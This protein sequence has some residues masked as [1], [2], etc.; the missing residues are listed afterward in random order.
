VNDFAVRVNEL[1]SVE[2]LVKRHR[3]HFASFHANHP[4]KFLAGYQIG[5]GNAKKRA[6]DAVERRRGCD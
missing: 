3:I 1:H 5:S 2:C 4:A 6:G